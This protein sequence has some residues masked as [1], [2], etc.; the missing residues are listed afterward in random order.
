MSESTTPAD[1]LLQLQTAVLAR[2]LA[3]AYLVSITKKIEIGLILPIQDQDINV[4]ECPYLGFKA[5]GYSKHLGKVEGYAA[6]YSVHDV[7]MRIDGRCAGGKQTDVRDELLLLIS[8]LGVV[9][10]ARRENNP[11]GFHVGGAQAVL[12]IP[13]GGYISRLSAPRKGVGSWIGELE[14]TWETRVRLANNYLVTA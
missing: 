4:P 3:S 12:L 2:L 6:G 7:F 10:G 5:M 9:L 1:W 8:T 11:Y 14:Y 13:G